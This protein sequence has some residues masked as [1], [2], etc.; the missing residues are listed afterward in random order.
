MNELKNNREKAEILSEFLF[1]Q[2]FGNIILHS[3]IET[4]IDCDKDSG[5]YGSI[6]HKT[7]KLLLEKHHMALQNVRG[8]GY[9]I[10][11]PDDFTDYALGYYR[12]GIGTINRGKKHLENAPTEHMSKDALDV[13]RRVNDRAITLEAAM[14]GASVELKTLA[15]K[16]HPLAMMANN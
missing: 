8:Q 10:V 5:Q 11:S 7:K 2:G 4:E 9:K 3:E 1:S 14:R 15:R 12:R 16:P 6:I 13:Y